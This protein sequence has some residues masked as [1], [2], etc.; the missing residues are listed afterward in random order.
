M[1]RLYNCC[2][3]FRLPGFKHTVKCMLTMAGMIVAGFAVVLVRMY[4]GVD[5]GVKVR[6]AVG[7]K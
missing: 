7:L 3:I 5:Y 2:S 6:A 4:T 1:L